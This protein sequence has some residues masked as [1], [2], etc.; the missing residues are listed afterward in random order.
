MDIE[1]IRTKDILKELG[2]EKRPGQLLMG[3]AA[4]TQQCEES[5]KDKML[6]KNLDIIALNDVSRAGEGFSSDSNNI[7][8]FFRDGAEEDLGSADKRMLCKTDHGSCVAAIP[9]ALR[10]ADVCAG[11]RRYR[12]FRR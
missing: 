2:A 9:R 12:T 4:E 11:D 7:R 1:L 10:R 6:R 8:L 3:F 5:A